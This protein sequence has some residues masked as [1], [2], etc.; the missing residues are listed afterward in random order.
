[1]FNV[2]TKSDYGFIVMLELAKQYKKSCVPL[3]QIAANKKL[4]VG[5]LVQLIQPLVK[6]GL[7]ISKEGKGGGYAL[8]KSPQ[9]ISVLTILEALEGP[10]MLVKCLKRNEQQ[11]PGF[12]ECEMRNVWQALADEMRKIL[13][14]K[15]LA[16]LMKKI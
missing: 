1:M 5:Y 16:D 12:A 7:I 8:A 14:K 10:A 3:A 6:D 15:T 11:C 4:S 9:A 2:S 13:K